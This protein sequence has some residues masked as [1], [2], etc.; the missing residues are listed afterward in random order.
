MRAADAL[1]KV[2]AVLSPDDFYREAHRNIFK[3]RTDPGLF[4]G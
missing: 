2:L 3:A 4:A 1:P